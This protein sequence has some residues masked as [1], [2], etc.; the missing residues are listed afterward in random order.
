VTMRLGLLTTVFLAGGALMS[1]EMA[2]FRLVEPEF[3]SGIEVWG[4]LISVFLGGLAI[5]AVAGGWLTPACT[6]GV[7]SRLSWTLA[8]ASMTATGRPFWST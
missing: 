2:S 7:T 3:G 8:P 1:L 6:V 5:G 4:S